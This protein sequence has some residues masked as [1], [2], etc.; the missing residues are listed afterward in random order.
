MLTMSPLALNAS[1]WSLFLDNAVTVSVDTLP[2][3]ISTVVLHTPNITVSIKDAGECALVWAPHKQHCC[4]SHRTNVVFQD[5]TATAAPWLHPEDA[6]GMLLPTLR[7]AN[8]QLTHRD[9]AALLNGPRRAPLPDAPLPS[10]FDAAMMMMEEKERA[11]AAA[12]SF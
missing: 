2:G 4:N 7:G 10:A 12:K 1:T 6:D 3:N 8:G 11:A 9:G 5:V